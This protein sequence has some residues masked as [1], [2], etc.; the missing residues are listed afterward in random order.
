MLQ[1]KKVRGDGTLTCPPVAMS[2]M[3]RWFLADPSLVDSAGHCA[4]YLLAVASPLRRAGISVHIV[5]NRNIDPSAEDLAGCL[6]AFTLR[7]EEMPVLPGID[8]ASH[9]GAVRLAVQRAKLLN[10][11]L[12]ALDTQV[13]FTSSDTV[14]IN[15]LR[16]WSLV[17]IVAWLESRP[18][19]DA[20]QI[21]LILHYTPFPQPGVFTSTAAEYQEGLRR[22]ANSSHRSKILLC[23]DSAR[24]ADQYDALAGVPVHV[25]PIPHSVQPLRTGRTETASLCI[26][27]A[28]EARRD[29]GFHLLP[30]LVS[31]VREVET[32]PL[33]T[34][35]FQAYGPAA[36][37]IGDTAAK[38][39][40]FDEAVRLLPEPMCETEYEAFLERIDL[41]LIPYLWAPYNAQTSG[42]YCEAAALGIPAI[43]PRDTWMAD[44]V[45]EMRNGVIFEAGD[46]ESLSIACIEAIRNYPTL[47]EQA[48]AAAPSWRAEHCAEAFVDRLHH[49]LSNQK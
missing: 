1:K 22:V 10:D 35:E 17:D 23:T 48:Q 27:F 16:H 29:K 47:S 46:A 2:T 12:N 43:V 24:L 13:H 5:G 6:A 26:G 38:V 39:L 36:N 33:L 18:L 11:D 4:R 14:L 20:P 37:D 19:A 41:M 31:R 3:S 28:G 49:L 9:A 15:S 30:Y 32:D 44:R 34:F 45:A 25:V 8:A 42:V 7:C 21:I 40:Q